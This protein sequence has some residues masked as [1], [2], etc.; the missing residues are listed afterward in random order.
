MW[1]HVEHEH[2]L[3]LVSPGS[4]FSTIPCHIKYSKYQHRFIS[5]DLKFDECL[6]LGC[7]SI[8]IAE[9]EFS[10]SMAYNY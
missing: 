6:Q 3:I 4:I 9:K 8:H 2:F 1:Q 7:L 10:E 5:P